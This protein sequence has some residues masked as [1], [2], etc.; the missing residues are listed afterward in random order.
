[1]I[2][3]V[4]RI[5]NTKK[6]E[7]AFKRTSD[8]CR[9]CWLYLPKEERDFTQAKMKIGREIGAYMRKK[10]KLSLPSDQSSQQ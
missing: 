8:V 9:A 2:L 7:M 3:R 6:E 4:C 1:M 5:C 10:S